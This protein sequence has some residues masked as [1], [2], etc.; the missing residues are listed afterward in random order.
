[1]T[2]DSRQADRARLEN[3]CQ[4]VEVTLHTDYVCIAPIGHAGEH[5]LVDAMFLRGLSADG[6]PVFALPRTGGPR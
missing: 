4:A 1:M 3:T 6:R 2:V 5:E